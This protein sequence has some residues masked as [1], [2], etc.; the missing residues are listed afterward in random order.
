MARDDFPAEEFDQR[1][2][3]LCARMAEVGCDVFLIFHPTSILW[4]TGAE[5]KGYQSFQCLAVDAR[6]GRLTL[7]CRRAEANEVLDE[8]RVDH[9]LFW[10][11]AVT[12]PVDAVRTLASEL[13]VAGGGTVGMEVPAHFLH[14]DHYARLRDV[15]AT[16]PAIFPDLANELRWVRSPAEI[17]YL[18]EAGRIADE[19]MGQAREAVAVGNPE[20]AIALAIYRTLLGS[21][22]DAP[23]VPPNIV[24]G[25]RASYSH[26]AAGD[27]RL[28]HGD[29]GNV[30]FCVPYRRYAVSIGRCFAVGEASRRLR[31]IHAV[32]RDAADAA[33]DVVGD[34]VSVKAVHRA[35]HDVLAGAGMDDHCVHTTGY[36]VA[37]AFPPSTGESLQISAGS[38]HVLKAG[39]SLSICPNIFIRDENIGVRIVD[40]VIVRARGV[41]LL[42]KCPRDLIVG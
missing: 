5:T 38:A 42:T 10:G 8:A 2:A 17:S 21:G 30:E 9:C 11:G 22:A 12:D 16:P 31:D 23:V 26:G 35:M 4:L 29:A 14:P 39:M 37:P 15:F 34:G 7:I 33:L 27:R 20:R 28:R 13:G 18:R 41:E 6:S 40:N 36:S 24:S 3:R 32:V 25:P 19:A 1:R